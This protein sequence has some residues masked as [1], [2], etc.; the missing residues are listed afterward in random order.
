MSL[1]DRIQTRRDEIERLFPTRLAESGQYLGVIDDASA[2]LAAHRPGQRSLR[3]MLGAPDERFRQPLRVQRIIP[4]IATLHTQSAIIARTVA[5][6][7]PENAIILDVI[8]QRAADAA[9]R[10]DAVHGCGLRAR[11]ERQ[12]QR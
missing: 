9:I 4:A 2:A 3:I 11:H 12:R 5:P 10:T 6:L 7:G 8:G 1:L